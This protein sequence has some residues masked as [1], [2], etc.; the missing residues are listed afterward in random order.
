[1][2]AIDPSSPRAFYDLQT[3]L[4]NCILPYFDPQPA[5][6]CRNAAGIVQW[7]NCCAGDPEGTAPGGQFVV[8]W[9]RD[10]YSEDGRSEVN[11]VNDDMGCPAN[12]FVGAEFI[13]NV[14]RCSK[15]MLQ[16]GTAPDC[17]RVAQEALQVRLDASAVRTGVVCC[18]TPLLDQ[19]LSGF[20][21]G[22]T[23]AAGAGGGC[24]GSDTLV[25]LYLPN[26]QP[27]V[28]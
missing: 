25:R 23:T 16:D 17:D 3:D 18:L 13:I 8:S 26:C 12:L 19:G 10:F 27:C 28:V 20:Q 4:A 11:F 9:Q 1:M 22:P 7:A 5:R 2:T 15:A 21:L 14:M 6:I 24:I